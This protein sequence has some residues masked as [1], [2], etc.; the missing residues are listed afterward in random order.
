[1]TSWGSLVRA[2]YRPPS[3][4][5][6]KTRG[7]RLPGVNA[8]AASGDRIGTPCRRQGALFGGVRSDQRRR[9]GRVPSGWG[10][11]VAAQISGHPKPGEER[12]VS[13]TIPHRAKGAKQRRPTCAARRRTCPPWTNADCLL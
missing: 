6:A 8:R 7:F 5:P 11:S 3:E 13:T 2:Q 1:S 4:S 12:I 10:S 9:R